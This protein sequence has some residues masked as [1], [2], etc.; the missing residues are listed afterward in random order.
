MEPRETPQMHNGESKTT[1]IM[2][3]VRHI[4]SRAGH[5]KFQVA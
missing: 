4:T 5:T 1:Q 2:T 3:T